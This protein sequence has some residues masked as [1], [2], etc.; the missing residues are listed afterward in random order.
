MTFIF[1]SKFIQKI[2][3]NPCRYPDQIF[4]QRSALG[5]LNI[6]WVNFRILL[7]VWGSAPQNEKKQQNF[8]LVLTPTEVHLVDHVSLEGRRGGPLTLIQI[9]GRT[10][11]VTPRNQLLPV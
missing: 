10:T 3:R 1:F 11:Y 2:L 4:T 5:P 9:W 6:R 8:D 7:P